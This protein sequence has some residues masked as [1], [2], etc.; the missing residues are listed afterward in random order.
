MDSIKQKDKELF[1]KLLSEVVSGEKNVS[2]PKDADLKAL[3]LISQAHKVAG[4]ICFA[5]KGFEP[6]NVLKLGGNRLC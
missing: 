5:L 6:K 2:I 1:L 3:Y 4:A